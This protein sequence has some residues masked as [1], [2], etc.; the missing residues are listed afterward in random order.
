MRNST[1]R[2]TAAAAW[3]CL[4]WPL[5]GDDFFTPSGKFWPEAHADTALKS[6]SQMKELIEVTTAVIRKRLTVHEPPFATEIQR[7]LAPL[8]QLFLSIRDRPMRTKR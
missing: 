6:E 7:R 1:W 3:S 8:R 2:A 4:R 5:Q